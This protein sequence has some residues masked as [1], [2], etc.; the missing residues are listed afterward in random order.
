MRM[1]RLCMTALAATV[2]LGA[3]D[4]QRTTRR[5]Y[6]EPIGPPAPARSNAP[7][8]SATG[9]AATRRRRKMQ[10]AADAGENG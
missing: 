9:R 6:G 5:L 10:E 2:A 7:R 8:E 1:G 4:D 3:Y